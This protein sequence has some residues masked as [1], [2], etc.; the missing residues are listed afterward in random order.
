MTPDASYKPTY[1]TPTQ[2][3]CNAIREMFFHRKHY[4]GVVPVKDLEIVKNGKQWHKAYTKKAIHQAIKELDEEGYI[5]L[6]EK[7]ENWL[8]GGAMH[9]MLFGEELNGKP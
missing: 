2:I 8:W 7:K 4:N 6:D 9:E 3:A 5:N 1:P